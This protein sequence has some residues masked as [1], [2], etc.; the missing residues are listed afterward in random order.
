M[1]RMRRKADAVCHRGLWRGLAEQINEHVV[2]TEP[3]HLPRPS[4]QVNEGECSPKQ[5]AQHEASVCSSSTATAS[6]STAEI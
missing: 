4:Q 5:V 6:P 2:G 3:G 1:E